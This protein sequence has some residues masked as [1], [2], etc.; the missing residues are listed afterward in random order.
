MNSLVSVP[1][2]QQGIILL[3][4]FIV[5]FFATASIFL[6]IVSNNVIDQRGSTNTIEALRDTKDALI[7]YAVLHGD[8]YGAAGAGPGHLPCPDTNNN[9]LENSPCVTAIGRLPISITLPSAAMFPLSA[10]DSGV[11]QQIWYALSDAFR[12]NPTGVVNTTTTGNITVDGQTGIA[13]VIMFPDEAL[14]SQTRPNNN[15]ANY[16]ES[17]N[18][19]GT[20][21]VSNNPANP[22]NFNDQVLAI[23]INEI[24]SPVTARIAE[25]IKIQLD[26]YHGVNGNYPPD[27]TEFNTAMGG[28]PAWFAS[29][30]WAANTTYT[31]LTPDTGSVLFTGC[32]I[33]YTLDVAVISVAKTSSFC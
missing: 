9:G 33:T 28:A 11:D 2:R 3:V 32:N 24:M 8:Y 15:V 22:D 21:F 25:T 7:A 27:Q 13:A 10:Y 1:S 14:V 31:Q 23:S 26:I 4:L 19:V 18:A 6:T 30:N 5:V 20:A 16:L 12:R 17:G 29:N